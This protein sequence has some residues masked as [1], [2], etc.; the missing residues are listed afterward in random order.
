VGSRRLNGSI[1]IVD[2]Q[3]RWLLLKELGFTKIPALLL[4]D[5]TPKD[6]ARLFA[7][8]NFEKNLIRAFFHYRALL[9]AED[10]HILAVNS[11]VSSNNFYVGTKLGPEASLSAAGTIVKIYDKHA[12]VVSTQSTLEGGEILDRT[13]GTINKAW[14]GRTISW[15]DA[16]TGGMLSGVARWIAANEAVSVENLSE[17]LTP[18][19][20]KVLLGDAARM[21]AHGSGSGK[22]RKVDAVIEQIF[23]KRFPMKTAKRKAAA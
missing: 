13:L 7:D 10:E 12:D 14:R 19:N 21:H 5:L 17:A 22:G 2:G 6:E 4:N 18:I 16:K 3:Q 8:L 1:A 9:F 20:P 11:V 15:T 23:R